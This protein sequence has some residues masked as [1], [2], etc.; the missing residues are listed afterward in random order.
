MS[1]MLRRAVVPVLAVFAL[2]ALAV[3]A[4][5][6]DRPPEAS[7][8]TDDA[9]VAYGLREAPVPLDLR[10][11]NRALVGLGSYLVNAVGGCNDCHT[12]PTYAPGVDHNP[13]L[14]GDGKINAAW[15]LAGGLEFQL[16]PG[17][18]VVSA[19]LTPDARGNPAG[20]T[21]DA[22][23][24]MLRTGHD[25]EEDRILQVMP[26]P[27]YRFMTDRDLR[28]VYEYLRAVPRRATPEPGTCSVPGEGT[29][30]DR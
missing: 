26:W 17:A 1:R 16:G 10:G 24:E 18:S 12:C 15:H 8:A 14:G 23:R 20:L 19:N 27:A 28:A 9:R 22:F 25:K 21:F 30:S 5:G 4:G 13:F 3:A 6:R 29:I 2:A 11:R 7:A